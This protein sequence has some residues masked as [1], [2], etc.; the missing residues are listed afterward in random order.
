M[1]YENYVKVRVREK[2]DGITETFRKNNA[3]NT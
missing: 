1:I 3:K 2:D